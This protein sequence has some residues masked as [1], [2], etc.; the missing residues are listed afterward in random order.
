M[1]GLLLFCILQFALFSSYAQT[2]VDTAS[3]L[4]EGTNSFTFENS[5]GQ[6]TVYYVYTAPADQG[7]LLTVELPKN[8]ISVQLTE[9]GNYNTMINGITDGNIRIFPIGKGQKVYL[10]ISIYNETSVSFIATLKDSDVEG[11]TTCETAIPATE[12]IFFVPSYYDSKNHKTN[13]TFISY[14]C[15]E[16]GLLEMTLGGYAVNAQI[17]EGCEGTGKTLTFN[18]SGSKYIAKHAVEAGKS[19]IMEVSLYSPMMASFKLTH[20]VE[21]ASCDMPFLGKDKDNILPKATGKYWYQYTAVKDGYMLVTSENGLPG[22]KISIYQTCLDYS[23]YATIDGYFAI[24]CQVNAN[25]TYLICIERA[26]ETNEDQK[27]DITV[28]DPEA[29][30]SF[31]LPKTLAIGTSVVPQFDGTYYYKITVPEG[32]SRFLIIDA[33][34]ANLQSNNTNVKLFTSDNRY[35]P[36]AQGKDY[37]K[38]EVIGGTSYMIVWDCHEGFNSFNFLS[39]YEEIAQGDVC[40]NPLLANVGEND[41]AAGTIKY[42]QYQATKNGWLNINMEDIMVTVS[43]PMNCQGNS[44]DYEAVREGFNTKM[45]VKAGE[46][47]LIKFSNINEATR[48][49]LS[50]EEY[51]EGESCELAIPIQEGDTP[52]PEAILNYWVKYTATQDGM[53]TVNSDIIYEQ[54]SDYSKRSSVSVKVGDC[55]A[56]PV[57]IMQTNSEGTWFEGQFIVQKDDILYIN[58]ITC[59]VQSDK[60]LSIAIRDLQPGE[61]CSVPIPLP[62]EEVTFP[63]ATR[64]NPIWYA[65]NLQP[66]EFK[67]TSE[68]PFTL[69]LYGGCD[70]TTPLAQTNYFY[71]SNTGTSEYKLAYTVPTANNYVLKLEM[72][73]ADTKVNVSGSA[74]ITDI[75]KVT[76]QECSIRTEKNA[77][78]VNPGVSQAKVQIYDMV[79]RQIKSQT[80]HAITSFVVPQGYYLVKVG[81]Y[82]QKIIVMN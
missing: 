32:N 75:D 4:T 42:Y 79:G 67:V 60:K 80:I 52:L 71:D 77:I 61:A 51:K 12:T 54:T 55:S 50:E 62:F 29:G 68:N 63:E 23:P 30:D 36:I 40:S 49:T 9:D 14:T 41:L 33:K 44:R 28:K 25:S 16:D 24:R 7:K 65:I 20:P 46:N 35:T 18:N 45:E 64:S 5:T 70:E 66:G 78:I 2:T 22:G 6:N 53:V 15:T 57:Y 43:F 11:G 1:R 31:D 26:D 48:F 59:T 58:I 56:Y 34:A 73:Y 27:F 13:P 10:S 19:Y 82:T 8:S 76:E 38:N 21:G 3:P 17:R 74:L 37:I 39:S 47:Y 69:N 72:C 81:S